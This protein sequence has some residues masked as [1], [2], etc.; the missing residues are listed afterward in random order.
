MRRKVTTV[1]MPLEKDNK[2]SPILQK[3]SAYSDLKVSAHLLASLLIA[4]SGSFQF[5]FSHQ[6]QGWSELDCCT[7]VNI[8]S[9]YRHVTLL[10]EKEVEEAKPKSQ[11][12]DGAAAELEAAPAAVSV[13]RLNNLPHPP[14]PHIPR[15]P[16]AGCPGG[17]GP[18]PSPSARLLQEAWP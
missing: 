11:K 2:T 18:C 10:W 17:R 16:G 5:S 6:S 3:V 13:L 14:C 9:K 8:R 4:I 12:G 15:V 7:I 1:K